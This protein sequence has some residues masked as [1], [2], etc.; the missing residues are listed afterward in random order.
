[1]PKLKIVGWKIGLKK[2]SMTQI[3]RIEISPTLAEAKMCTDEVLAGK[4]F[5][6]NIEDEEKVRRAAKDLEETGAIIE[7]EPDF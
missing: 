7:I 3:L 1:M 5:E 6:F 4:K 2:I